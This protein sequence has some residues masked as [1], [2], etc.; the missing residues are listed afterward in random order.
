MADRQTERSMIFGLPQSGKSERART[1]AGKAPRVVMYDSMGHD[2]TDGVV[3]DSLP[4]F[5]DA[6]GRW[7]RNDGFRIIYR[8]R[9]SSRDE[10]KAAKKIDPEFAE[11][12]RLV[13][14]CADVLFVVDELQMYADAGEFD[15][16]FLDIVTHGRHMGADRG[17]PGVELVAATQIPQGLGNKVPALVD[18]WYIFQTIHP[19][20]LRFFRDI[21]F[22]V[23]EADI[24]SL[25]K[26]EYIYYHR[27]DDSYWICKDDLTTGKTDRREREYLYD[28]AGAGRAGE[29][30]GDVLPRTTLE[31]DATNGPASV[32][33]AQAP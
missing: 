22:G 14:E 6:I 12:C 27:G 16:E 10:C 17:I 28:R 20:H 30:G 11:V 5:R 1:M 24:R 13:K 9:G 21:C 25:Q 15:R 18:H 32:S 23:D 31:D 4:G 8:P 3:V 33:A 7:Y 2:Y 29:R 26:Y 19:A